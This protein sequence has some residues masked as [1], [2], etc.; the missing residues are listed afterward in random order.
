MLLLPA[1]LSPRCPPAGPP[2]LQQKPD[3]LPSVS[4]GPAP[5]STEDHFQANRCPHE[6]D[7]AVCELSSGSRLHKQ[8]AHCT[9]SNFPAHRMWGRLSSHLAPLSPSAR[10]PNA[11]CASLHRR[12]P[13]LGTDSRRGRQ[14]LASSECGI[15]KADFLLLQTLLLPS[16]PPSPSET[17]VPGQQLLSTP[18]TQ[19][20]ALAGSIH[21]TGDPLPATLVHNTLQQS[22]VSAEYRGPAPQW[23]CHSPPTED[24]CCFGGCDQCAGAADPGTLHGLRLGLLRSRGASVGFAMSF[25]DCI[26]KLTLPPSV[27]SDFQPSPPTR[28]LVRRGD[29][30]LAPLPQACSFHP[31]PQGV[32][33]MPGLGH[34]KAKF[35]SQAEGTAHKAAEEPGGFRDHLACR[36]QATLQ[37]LVVTGTPGAVLRGL[38][39]RTP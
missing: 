7:A 29:G 5:I 38:P 32:P 30:V 1:Q 26:W 19:A 2:S 34:L 23:A 37:L 35:S 10:S 13:G 25:P 9:A 17:P 16:L 33:P 12:Q 8:T 3:V 21:S 24:A 39:A 4:R 20:Q 18:Y 6:T 27:T 15:H 31:V 22:L 11:E 28:S 36:P 14:H